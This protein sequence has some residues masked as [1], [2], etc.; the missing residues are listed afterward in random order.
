MTVSTLKRLWMDSL[1]G[2]LGLVALGGVELH[3]WNA[4]VENFERA[5]RLVTDLDPGEGVP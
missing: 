4:T 3:P 2:F 5:D 1:D